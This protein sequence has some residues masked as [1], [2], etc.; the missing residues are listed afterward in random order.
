MC[1][2][3]KFEQN[4]SKNG[5]VIANFPNFPITVFEFI[6]KIKTLFLYVFSPNLSK[7]GK[8]NGRVIA[9]FLNLPITVFEFI[10]KIKTLFLCVFSPNLSKIGQKMAEL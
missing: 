3:S 8:K 7:I 6:I 2:Q 1:I 10:N 5:R 9:N 4:R